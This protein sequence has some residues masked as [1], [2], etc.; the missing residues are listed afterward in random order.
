MT[1]A[2]QLKAVL[3]TTDKRGVFFGYL[4]DQPTD[5]SVV[6]ERARMIVYWSAETRGVLGLAA[7]GPAK[8]SRVT[9]QVPL[10]TLTSVTAVADCT[11]KAAEAI[12]KAPWQ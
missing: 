1:K 3:V 8:G 4:K 5:T 6:L 9:P 7:D 10:L 2:K 11:D 12:E